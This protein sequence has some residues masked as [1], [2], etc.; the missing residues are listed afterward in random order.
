MFLKQALWALF[1]P[2]MG[3]ALLAA[4][5]CETYD[6]PPEARLVQP[7]GGF[8]TDVSPVEIQFTE[9][10]DAATI[11]LSVWPSEYDV[12]GAFR[13]GV[14]PIIDACTL[15]TSPCALGLELQ[16]NDERTKLTLIQHDAF[17]ELQGRPLVIIV[18]AGLK[19]DMKRTR[20]VETSFDFQVN[21]RCGN[22]AVDI[23]MTTGVIT[24]GADLPVLLI[25]LFMYFDLAVDPATGRVLIVGTFARQRQEAVKKGAKN[26]N[27]QDFEAE[28]GDTGWAVQFTACMVKQP[29]GGYFLQS[30]PFDVNITVLGAIPVT[31]NDFMV[32][33]TIRA[34]AGDQ[35]RDTAS[36]T[37]STSGG[38]FTIGEEPTPV[39]PITTA[40]NGLGVLPEEIPEG[41]P[42][43]CDTDPC[44]ALD[45]SGGDCQLESPWAPGDVCPSAEAQ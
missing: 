25:P 23:E 7:T 2:I 22:E 10:V 36:G 17:A 5:G 34:K 8:W 30:D 6:P 4:P 40:W 39:D 37:L 35:G 18:A 16:L 43:T 42:R 31:L 14:V 32:Q 11:Q 28:L 1:A 19:D 27:P 21:P 29:D 20:K 9:P 45:L 24:M 12:E 44:A 41:L 33:G 38:S 3:V 13:P 26:V 15:A